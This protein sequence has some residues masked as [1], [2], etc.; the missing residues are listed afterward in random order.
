MALSADT[1]RDYELGNINELPVKASTCI[2]EGA[3]VGDDAAGYMRGLVAG[4]AFRG[5]AQRKAD[6]SAVATDG[7]INVKVISKGL[8]KLTITGIAVTDV[9]KD[10]YASADGSFTLTQGANSLI[11]KVYRYVTTDTCVVAFLAEGQTDGQV[12]AG[13]TLA[14]AQI[15]VGNGS[16]VAAARAVSGDVTINNSGAV[17]IGSNKILAAMISSSQ[18]TATKIGAGAVLSAHISTAQIIST[19]ISEST[20]TWGKLDSGCIATI[21]SLVSSLIS[22]HSG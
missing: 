9:G 13:G 4:D 12:A 8:V 11:G 3:A 6:N 7:A 16:G 17:A 19:A 10:V 21:A 14:S 18:V 15:L 1:P 22:V 20:I 2:Y 5:F